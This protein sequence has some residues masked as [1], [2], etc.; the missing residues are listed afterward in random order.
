MRQYKY[1]SRY[2][3]Y[4][5]RLT[6]D[7]QFVGTTNEWIIDNYYSVVET[8]NMIKEFYRK[9]KDNKKILIENIEL[10][11]LIKGI[12]EK[13][14]YDLDE[15]ILTKEINR[16][17]NSSGY[18][19]TY[20]SIKIIPVLIALV[21]QEKLYE[22]SV[23]KK[24]TMVEQQ[25]LR[26]LL[27]EIKK[28][29]L[30]DE[31]FV[32]KD[33]IDV[34]VFKKPAYLEHLNFELKEFG[35]ESNELFVE[36]NEMLDDSGLDVKEILHAKHDIS[37]QNNI[38]VT[39]L[40]SSYKLIGKLTVANL[41]DK[42]S[43]TE[44]ILQEEAIY[45]KMTDET[46]SMYRAR[47]VKNTRKKDEYQYVETLVK[48]SKTD[49]RHIGFYLFPKVNY[50]LRSVVYTTS[51]VLLTVL[52]SL[53]LSNY[54]FKSRILSFLLVLIPVSEVVI[55]FVNKVMGRFVAST[56]PMP[57]M[58]YAE[59]I[60]KTAKTMVVIPTIVKDNKKV[61]IMFKNLEAYYLS[62][63]TDNVYFTLVGDCK[64]HPSPDYEFDDEVAEYGVARAKELNEKY[65]KEIFFFV[66]RRRAFNPGE[67]TFL[68]YERKRGGLMHF[69]KLLLGT[70]TK[71]EHEKYI[72]VETLGDFKEKIKYVVTLDTDT[73]LGIEA[74]P[75]L[76]GLMS[77]PLNK[78]VLNKE[79]TK[80]IDGYAIVQPRISVD[81]ES[82]NQSAYSQL[83]AGAG[84]FD[85]Y[86]TV[87]P[88]FYFD[89]FGE[90]SFVGKGIYD[91]E[92]FEEVL[93][94]TFPE[95]Q[96]LSHDLIEGNYLR[97][98][99]ASDV[100]F[101]EDFPSGFLVD[102]ARQHR[103]ARGDVQIIA[104]LKNK[105]RTLSNKIVKNPL[106]AIERF[107]IFDNVRRIFL[108]PMLLLIILLAFVSFKYSPIISLLIVV[109][110]ILLPILMYL[111]D[112][113]K[114]QNKSIF[115]FKYYDNLLFGNFAIMSRVLIGFVTIPYY[116][117]HYMNAFFKAVYRMTISH[118]NMLN[119]VTAE[120]AAKNISG[121]LKAYFKAFKPNLV[122][123]FILLLTAIFTNTNYLGSILLLIFLFASAP[124][125]L[126]YISRKY[127]AKQKLNAHEEEELS[128]I[129]Y[130]TWLYFKDMLTEKNNYLIPDNYQVGRE[131]P[132]DMKTSPTNIGM[133]LTAIL[134]AQ[135]FD[136]IDVKD[137]LIYF[138]KIFNTLEKLEKWNGHLYNWV[139][140]HTLKK[141]YPS[142][143]SSVDSANLAASLLTVKSY[144]REYDDALADRAS[145]LFEEMDFSFFYTEQEVFSI[146]YDTIEEKLSPYCYNKFAS[147]S[148]IMSFVAIVKGDVDSKH[149][150]CLDKTLTKHKRHKGLVSWG[151][152][153]FEYFMPLLFMKTYPNTLLDESYYFASFC[154]KDYMNEINP[155]LP[156]GISESAYAEL[157][158]GENYKYRAFGTPYLKLIEDKHQRVVI[159]PYASALAITIEPKE[160]YE[161]LKTFKDMGMYS[162][163]GFYESY[164][165]DNNAKVAAYFAHHQGMLLTAISNYI[166]D[167]AIQE[168]FHEDLRVKSFE[169]LLKEKVQLNPVIDLKMFGYKKY[170]YEREKVE[171]DIREFNYLSEVPELSVLSNGK[172]A[173]LINDR[174]NGF[175]RYETTQLNRYRKIT[176]QEY[177]NFLYLRDKDTGR[178]WSN[179]Y[180][181]VNVEP[182]K[183][184]IVFS[185]D[186]I[187][188]SRSDQ[189][190]TTKTEII[191]TKEND[192]EI[193][194]VTLKNHSDKVKNIELTTYS[195]AII[196]ENETDITHR[197]FHN[198]FVKS[199]YDEATQT[200]LMRRKNTS[201]KES[202]YFI[203]RIF[204][205]GELQTV[206]YETERANFVGRGHNTD[207]P[208][209]MHVDA[210]SNTVGDNI[211]PV[212]SLRSDVRLD[213]GDEKT[214]YLI[215]GFSKSRKQAMKIINDY[216][217]ETNI[218]LASSYATEANNIN[219]KLLN[220]TGPDIRNYNLMLNYLYQ[221]SKH[222]VNDVRKDLL[223]KNGLNQTNLW[224]FDITGD[225]PII[226]VEISESESLAF[227]LDMLKAYEYFKTRGIFVDVVILNKEKE[228]YKPIIDR[229][230]EQELYRIETLFDFS[231]TPGKVYILDN[232]DVTEE[233]YILL[234]MVARITFNAEENLS[235]S[236]AIDKMRKENKML[237]FPERVIAQ[238]NPAK[239]KKKGLEFYNEYGGFI[240]DG[241]EYMVTNPET[242][243]PWSNVLVNKNFGSIVTNN[244]CG[245]TYSHNSQ[246][247][248]V[249][250]WTNDIVVDDKSEGIQVNGV[251]ADPSLARHGFGYSIFNNN[252]D[253]YSLNTTQFVALEDNIKFYNCHIVNELNEKKKFTL[254]FWINPT[255]GP[256]E[257]K[258]SR[259]L[260][261]E[262]HENMNSILIRNV[263]NTDFSHVTAFLTSTLPTTSYSVDRVIF[264][265]IDVEIELDAGESKNFAFMLGTEVKHADIKKLINK[266][267]A[268][269]KI[270]DELEKVKNFW[271][272]KLETIKV[273]T[274][275]KSFD[276]MMNGWY[277][278]QSIASRNYAKAGFYQVGGAFGYR[279]QLQDCTNTCIVD[280]QAAKDQILRNAK[281]QF[282]EGDVLHWWH[283]TNNFGLR[284]RYKD[285][286]LWLVYAVSEYLHITED[287]SI[288][289]ERVAFVT[290]P[291][292][293]DEEEERG[294]NFNYSSETAS[295][296]THCLLAI[297]RALSNMGANGLPLMG[298]GDWNDGMNKV[299]IGGKGTSVW[300][301]FFLHI[302][303]ER[304]IKFSKKHHPK[305]TV[306]Q[307]EEEN[308]K[309]AK[310]LN[311]VAWDGEY[312]LRAF[313]DNGNKLGS[314]TNDEAKIDLISQS[315]S[316][317]SG[318]ADQE[319]AEKAIRSVEKNLVDKD[320]KIVK[321][322]TPAFKNSKDIPGYIMDYPEGVRENGGQYTHSVAWYVIALIKMGAADLAYKYYSM[323]NPI[324][325]SLNKEDV[326]RY[327]VEPYVIAAD[328]Y[329]NQNNPGRGGWTWYTGS[330]AWFYNVGLKNIL[331]LDK[332]GKKLFIKPNVP[333]NWKDFEVEY[334]YVETTYKIKVIIGDKEKL[335]ID[336]EESKKS[337][338]RLTND[339]RLHT[340]IVNVKGAK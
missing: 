64:E 47:I 304:F 66:Y 274:P 171:N 308:E 255:F 175:S 77:H 105:V 68:G 287:Y 45:N 226:L 268:V 329:S 34:E 33:Y 159:S 137:T 172:Y 19:F 248:K 193:R 155:E 213:P 26:V 150:M 22:L 169:L 170:N 51:I 149:W 174:G 242:P 59:A 108:Y 318:V 212:M 179:T 334:K 118:K 314:H 58:D 71:E 126:W 203:N 178:F 73:G 272:E 292:L 251:L 246:M 263:Y 31:D 91:L 337:E 320:L 183:Y 43:K 325:R 330:A 279:D 299:G 198:L 138:D 24:E 324:N 207:N 144:L 270:D 204:I 259:Y 217:N 309:L 28:K 244:A 84:G 107:K 121:D 80:V 116:A 136:F 117:N 30:E 298:G 153:S 185:T 128:E 18:Y 101:I 165:Y 276:Y 321:L 275:D 78:P 221:T 162:D 106:N 72:Y 163:Y 319:R 302:V 27:S 37:I 230:V 336:G 278:Y 104:W 83:M 303:L 35:E 184:N 335:V 234:R 206:S 197:T 145:K 182:E 195:E 65:G 56:Q 88:N 114:L 271:K 216:S 250:S 256:N 143:V 300:L 122:T 187:K 96:I 164:D 5:V 191:V 123:A 223:T 261:S 245:F 67:G 228:K 21:V 48:K 264:K 98:G 125:L 235:F 241:K 57:K 214:I 238:S 202:S 157:D 111:K 295:I 17:Q 327:K 265:S 3:D 222:F 297:N 260:L 38:L 81:I 131:E 316:V 277:L 29:K 110:V 266:F 196:E 40:F 74:I 87:V 1:V 311:D 42:I 41:I 109:L 44:K 8:K 210:L 227:V 20:T 331:G 63:N 147:E 86:S 13:H 129:A 134:A 243:T 148:R 61:N 160:V 141:M 55:Q 273:K 53:F 142:Y 209:A 115:S 176:E 79:K 139:D 237:P 112:F 208:V 188:F 103:W 262:Y 140:I 236:E 247:F 151:G 82:T 332:Q 166:H 15:K 253:E 249:T 233:E 199:Y 158:N 177:G 113:L 307:F 9:D 92:V 173:V 338:I 340:V 201:K 312:Y 200:L 225:R 127:E 229:S 10:Y 267:S 317:L 323:I 167:G 220:V 54:M 258:S 120:D 294:I 231:G 70:L 239:I 52:L 100:E 315:F 189:A 194:K 296:Y 190:I 161:N 25:K 16:Y 50:K 240:N 328:I 333:S 254:T 224:K 99:Y 211:D 89:V 282:R 4:L 95:N 90:G 2:Y 36:L 339:K 288:L 313:F 76:V 257:E 289:D 192:A 32:L 218:S 291:V 97:C 306:G 280:P 285:D 46:K 215:Y 310:A 181:P 94:T 156:W 133:S 130:R 252:T 7:H 186:R 49:N 135:E 293:A 62:V 219:T 132:E 305:K 119:W 168:Y 301:G 11:N 75:K 146:G 85:V 286:Y 180:A 152:T 283:E 23:A 322:L 14:Y 154:Q 6:K 232:E 205:P 12:L 60:P 39:N 124:W 290:G 102:T 269:N 284:S 93:G 281:H 69:N 326:D